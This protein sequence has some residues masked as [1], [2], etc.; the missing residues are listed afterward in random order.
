MDGADVA[1]AVL[2]LGLT[3]QP[4]HAAHHRRSLQKISGNLTCKVA[5]LGY[6]GTMKEAIVRA[7]VDSKLKS[8]A[9]AVFGTLGINTTEAIR[10]FLSQVRLRRGLPFIVGIPDNSDLLLPTQMRQD[11]INSLYED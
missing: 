3:G 2:W 5:Q 9:E 1:K 7:R 11:A 10:M 4:L 8:D 6:N